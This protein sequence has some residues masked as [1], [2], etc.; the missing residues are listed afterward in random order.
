MLKTRNLKIVLLVQPSTA[1]TGQF[2][3]NHFCYLEFLANMVK[4]TLGKKLFLIS[5]LMPIKKSWKK[6]VL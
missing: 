6:S 3:L 4:L 1:V 5:Y 2:K